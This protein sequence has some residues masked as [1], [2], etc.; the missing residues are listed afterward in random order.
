M[1]KKSEI[2]ENFK[3]AIGSTVKSLSNYENVE[4]SFGNQNFKS[5]KISIKLPEIEQTNNKINYSKIRAL[6]DSESLRLRFS[7]NKTFKSYEPKG[8]ISKKLYKIAEKIRFEK[9]GSDQ[10]KG[11]KNNIEKYYQER[12]NSLDLKNSED[13]IIES[14]ENYLRVKFFES[15]NNKELEKKLKTYKKD[16]NEKFKEKI[17]Q[18]NDLAHNQAQYNSLISD[19][20][21]NMNLDENFE[22]EKKHEENNDKN[23]KNPKNQEQK[24]KEKEPEQ[25]EISIDSGVPHLENQTSESDQDGKEIEIENK[26]KSNVKKNIK[27]KLGDLKYKSYTE[28]FDEIIKAEDLENDEEL[29]RLRKNLDQQLL[30]LKN[31]IS[32]LANKLQRKV[33]AKQNRSWNFDL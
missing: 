2:L 4:V 21:A 27:N 16:L 5:E 28:E 25:Q 15:K 3:T 24:T 26:S 13:K 18:L 19:L 12:I 10:F 22:E 31:F 17:K 33:L 23:Q 8:N 30:Q 6:A 20:I 29:N 32:K 7:D 9:L 11:V 14:F 1:E